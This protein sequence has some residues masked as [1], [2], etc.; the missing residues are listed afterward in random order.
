M[1]FLIGP[2]E[3]ILRK[4]IIFIIHLLDAGHIPEQLPNK[5]F[6][7]FWHLNRQQGPDPAEGHPHFDCVVFRLWV[8]D[9]SVLGRAH[10]LAD[11]VVLPQEQAEHFSDEF[12]RFDRSFGAPPDDRFDQNFSEFFFRRFHSNFVAFSVAGAGSTSGVFKSLV[13]GEKIE[14]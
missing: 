14:S 11:G 2:I 7:F 4:L 3:L 9:V 10:Q 1:L 5:F 8:D 13:L 12:R 6:F